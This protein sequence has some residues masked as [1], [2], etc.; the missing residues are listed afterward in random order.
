MITLL[1]GVLEPV[2]L[3]V[4]GCVAG[5]Y[6]PNGTGALTASNSCNTPTRFCV[7]GSANFSLTQAGYFAVA[8][9]S[10]L[11]VGESKCEAGW[12]CVDGVA[13]ACP[14]GRF[15]AVEGSVNASC[16]GS[17]VSGY[18]CPGG[19]VSSQQEECGSAGQ[20]C[21]EVSSVGVGSRD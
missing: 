6:C 18:Y 12:Y 2:G 20:Y 21:P 9:V 19:S 10:G 11:Y 17:C 5:Y 8:G 16:D 3:V 1:V 15:G 4:V 7:S 13:F 14:A